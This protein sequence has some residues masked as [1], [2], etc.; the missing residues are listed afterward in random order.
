MLWSSGLGQWERIGFSG[1]GAPSASG[2]F[3]FFSFCNKR[4]LLWVV[5]SGGFDNNWD[6]G[7]QEIL[8]LLGTFTN[9]AEQTLDLSR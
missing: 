4:V 3:F 7:S 1:A 8:S 2:F 5:G 6:L 9:E